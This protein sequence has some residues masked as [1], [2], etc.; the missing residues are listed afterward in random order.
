MYRRR[1]IGHNGLI[2]EVAAK[3]AALIPDF[4]T[5]V[6]DM[7]KAVAAMCLQHPR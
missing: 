4:H 2:H 6:D 7:W 5:D 1:H 3:R